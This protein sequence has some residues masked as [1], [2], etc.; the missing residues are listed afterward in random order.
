[1]SLIHIRRGPTDPVVV[2]SRLNKPARC[3]IDGFA[4]T[5][6]FEVAINYDI[7]LCSENAALADMHVGVLPAWGLSQRLSK[8]SGSSVVKKFPFS[9]WFMYPEYTLSGAPKLYKSL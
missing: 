3:A 7:V 5:C 9:G 2:L 1:M 8:I 6:G 4:I